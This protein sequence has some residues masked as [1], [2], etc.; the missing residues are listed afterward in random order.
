[1]SIYDL[2]VKTRNG[3]DFDLIKVKRLKEILD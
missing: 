2:K 3:E 1:M